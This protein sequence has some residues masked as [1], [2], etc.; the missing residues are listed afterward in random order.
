MISCLILKGRGGNLIW[1][2]QVSSELVAIVPYVGF[3]SMGGGWFGLGVWLVLVN[4]GVVCCAQKGFW[5]VSPLIHPRLECGTQSLQYNIPTGPQKAPSV[6]VT[7]L[8]KLGIVVELSNSS[9]CGIWISA[10]SDG[11]V[12][13]SAAYNGCYVHQQIYDHVMTISIEKGYS[14]GKWLSPKIEELRCP[15]LQALTSDHC[16]AIQKKE[17]ISCSDPSISQEAC[18]KRQC[19]F[20]SSDENIPCYYGGKVTVQCTHKGQ[21]SIALSK[22]LT[23]PP[24]NMDSIYLMKGQGAVCKPVIRTNNFILFQF[25]LSSCGSI[26][27]E[28][29]N[30]VIYANNL[31]LETDMANPIDVLLSSDR[32]LRLHIKCHIPSIDEVK[33]HDLSLLTLTSSTHDDPLNPNMTIEESISDKQDPKNGSKLVSSKGVVFLPAD[34]PPASPITKSPLDKRGI[35]IAIVIGVTAFII[36]TIG[37]W[38]LLR[39]STPA[40]VSETLV[41]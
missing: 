6:R 35:R 34:I 4:S 12:T 7:A 27:K 13:L 14:F 26:I 15:T 36:L 40:S 37:L 22:D 3:V 32:T 21:F 28:M 38:R 39:K 23:V 18:E 19:C 8:D 20:D 25:P 5:R 1:K 17:R 29:E 24:L 30:H 16:S 11:S 2:L 10:N 33:E 41:S 31:V 9:D